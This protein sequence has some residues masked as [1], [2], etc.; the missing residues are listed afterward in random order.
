MSPIAVVGAPDYS[1][2]GTTNVERLLNTM[3][4]V[5]PGEGGFTNNESSGVATIDLRG[6]GTQ[7]SLVLVNG[8]RY[9][10]YDSRQVTDLNTIPAAL[11]GGTELVTGGSSAVYGSDAVGGVVNFILKDDFEGV[12]VTG[13]YDV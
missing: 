4:Q 6:L 3:P 7:R 11:V 2:S 8:R 10:F 1:L 12:E 5:I 13:Q 9:M